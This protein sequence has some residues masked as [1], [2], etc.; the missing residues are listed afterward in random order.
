MIQI[1]TKDRPIRSGRYWATEDIRKAPVIYHVD[2]H[3]H[4]SEL[5]IDTNEGYL[6]IN[7]HVFDG[8]LWGSS[9]IPEPL[10]IKI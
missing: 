1:Y 10:G 7:H 6:P 4:E 2:T 3:D 8:M 9:P 5:T